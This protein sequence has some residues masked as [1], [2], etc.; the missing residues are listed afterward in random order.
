MA[1]LA[2]GVSIRAGGRGRAWLEALA[3]GAF[4]MTVSLT[5]IETQP[6]ALALPAVAPLAVLMA[7]FIPVRPP[8]R[9]LPSA[10]VLGAALTLLYGE[11]GTGWYFFNS[12]VPG[13]HALLFVSRGGLMLLIAHAVG[14][15]LLAEGLLARRLGWAALGLGAVCMCEQGVTT[16]AFDKAEDR[17]VVSALAA[18]I[19]DHSGAFLYTP[20]DF[21][22]TP[23]LAAL[24]AMW[25]GL[26][27]GRPTLN[28]YS[29]GTPPAWRGF[30]RCLPRDAY[31]V[32][33]LRRAV[34]AW[35]AR[36]GGLVGPL[37]WIDEPAPIDLP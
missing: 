9:W 10:A 8:T 36:H 34:D 33:D 25:A 15:G 3:C 28:G 5:T 2:V 29:G 20:R 23:P 12:F 27:R 19:D 18:R 1:A 31:D 14:L 35:K 7:Q 22:G 13:G 32:R 6:E 21:Q 11:Q 16:P 37:Q 4:V 17:R 26:E 24:D 30:E